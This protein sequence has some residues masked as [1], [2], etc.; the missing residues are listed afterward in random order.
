VH[1]ELGLNLLRLLARPSVRA[2]SAWAGSPLPEAGELRPTAL[3]G[4]AQSILANRWRGVAGKLTRR[5]LASRVAQFWGQKGGVLTG[6]GLSTAS[7]IRRASST[8]WPA[9]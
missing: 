3:G 9:G 5:K 2:G 1:C 7:A 6:V 8:A 4:G